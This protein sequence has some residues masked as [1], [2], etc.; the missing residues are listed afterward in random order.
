M[1]FGLIQISEMVNRSMS[2]SEINLEMA[3]YLLDIDLM[4]A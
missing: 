4:F 2:L 3:G 1:V